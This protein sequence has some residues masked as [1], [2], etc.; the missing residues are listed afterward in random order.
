MPM[1][2]MGGFASALKCASIRE[3]V[4]WNKRDILR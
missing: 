3:E 2:T 1:P 4:I